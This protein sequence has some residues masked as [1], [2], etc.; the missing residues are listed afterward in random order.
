MEIYIYRTY[1]EWFK[2]KPAEVLE[3]NIC[4]LKNG[5]FA[6]DTLEDG[7]SYR[8][9]ISPRNN[10]AVVSK[11]PCGF[12]TEAKEINVYENIKSWKKCKPEISFNGQIC[13]DECGDSYVVFITEDG[14]KQFVSLEGIY[15]VSYKR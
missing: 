6:I 5:A 1:E 9:R 2:D 12:L 14:Y 3:G 13:E 4:I 10:F 7:V 11:L 15:S 8:Q